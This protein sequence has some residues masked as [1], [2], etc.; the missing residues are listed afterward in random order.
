M[1]DDVPSVQSELDDQ[2]AQTEA[3]TILAAISDAMTPPLTPTRVEASDHL[4]QLDEGTTPL[5]TKLGGYG[6]RG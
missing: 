1:I 6:W 3:P 2:I 4:G 5:L